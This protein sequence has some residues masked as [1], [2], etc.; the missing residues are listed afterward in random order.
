MDNKTKDLAVVR[1]IKLKSTRAIT[2]ES[3]VGP[4]VMLIKWGLPVK[5]C[6][7]VRNV[8]VAVCC[9][10]YPSI[11][12]SVRCKTGFLETVIS[13]MRANAL[14]AK[15]NIAENRD[16]SYLLSV[17]NERDS[18]SRS[19]IGTVIGKRTS[20]LDR[21]RYAPAISLLIKNEHVGSESPISLCT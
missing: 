8:M 18:T 13:P 10:P 21:M 9:C 20:K 7:K 19:K 6:L 1:G 12:R 11:T 5:F 4:P 17:V 14:N 3:R 2:A 16:Y 15:R